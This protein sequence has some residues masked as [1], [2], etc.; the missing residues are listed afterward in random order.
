VLIGDLLQAESEL[1]DAKKR[2]ELDATIRQARVLVLREAG[3]PPT[4]PAD[5][6]RLAPLKEKLRAKAK[7][8]LI[9]EELRRRKAV[10]MNLANEGF[11]ARKKEEEVSMKKRKA[12]QD[13]NWEGALRV[14]CFASF[15]AHARAG[16][17]PRAAR[18]FV[19]QFQ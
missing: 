11:E 1:S 13:A 5:D 16:S 17:E 14:C 12:E 8:L 6:E 18:R 7:E 9:D 19:A 10:K 2:E 3:L 15:G 4:T